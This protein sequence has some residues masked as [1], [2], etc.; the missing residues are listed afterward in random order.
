VSSVEGKYVAL[1]AARQTSYLSKTIDQ[2]GIGC[3]HG[4]HDSNT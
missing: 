3:D 2:G 1:A 4:E